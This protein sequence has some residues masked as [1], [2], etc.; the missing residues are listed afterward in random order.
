MK[1]YNITS[2]TYIGKVH[3]IADVTAEIFKFK[4]CSVVN[5]IKYINQESAVRWN[6]VENSTEKTNSESTN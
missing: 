1:S 3:L 5:F 4:N 6:K 2:D